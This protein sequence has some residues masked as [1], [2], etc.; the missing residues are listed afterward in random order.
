MNENKY[1]FLKMF[2]IIVLFSFACCLSLCLC[3]DPTHW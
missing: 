3:G 2:V 1:I